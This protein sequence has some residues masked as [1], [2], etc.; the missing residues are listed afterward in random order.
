MDFPFPKS[1]TCTSTLDFKK[2]LLNILVCLVPKMV[3]ELIFWADYDSN[4]ITFE[5]NN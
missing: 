3:Y 4:F 1:T 5:I 2:W